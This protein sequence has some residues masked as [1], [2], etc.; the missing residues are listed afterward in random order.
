MN[1]KILVIDDEEKIRRFV[2]I[3]LLTEGFDYCEADN[4]VSGLLA[5]KKEKPDVILLDLGLPDKDGFFVLSELRKWS[6]TP[7]LV[8][9]A[10]DTEDEKVKLLNGGANDYL[11]KPFGIKELIARINVLLRTTISSQQ[12]SLLTFENLSINL[13]THQAILNDK[14]LK[15]SKKEFLLLSYLA[16]HPQQLVHQETLLAQFWGKTHL[17]DKHYLRVCIGQLRKKLGD[18]ADTPQFIK[19]VPSLGYIFL[20]S[21][22]PTAHT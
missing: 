6:D 19:T 10:R 7:V 16:R 12:E 11:S 14:A 1:K 3:S 5:V 4:A 18:N 9:T 15:V 17:Q 22:Q 13:I 8:L 2:K 20:Q 21:V